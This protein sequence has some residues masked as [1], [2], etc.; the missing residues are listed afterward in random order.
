MHTHARTWSPDPEVPGNPGARVPGWLALMGPGPVPASPSH[1]CSPALSAQGRGFSS[2]QGLRCA[3]GL[4]IKAAG[5]SGSF[6]SPFKK[7]VAAPPQQPQAGLPGERLSPKRKQLC[8]SR[9]ACAVSL[10]RCLYFLYEIFVLYFPSIVCP[11][12][13]RGGCHP[14]SQGLVCLS[15]SSKC[16]LC[17]MSGPTLTTTTSLSLVAHRM[18]PNLHSRYSLPMGQSLPIATS[19]WE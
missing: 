2:Q 15:P 4:S 7:K 11:C 12:L 5:S 14:A 8:A 1:P 10:C 13:P 19:P 16:A 6:S 17:P 18:S 9:R 3:G